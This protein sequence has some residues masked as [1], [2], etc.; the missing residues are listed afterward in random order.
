MINNKRI[1]ISASL[2]LF[3]VLTAACSGNTSSITYEFT[4]VRRG[5]LERT[6]SSSGTIRPVS[7]VRI[8]P[9]MSGKVERVFVDFNDTVNRG[10]IL[11]QLNTDMLRLRRQQ[12]NAAV[13]KARANYELQLLNYN[14]LLLLAERNLISEYELRISRTNLDNLAA[15]LEVAETNLSVIETEI[16][17]YAYIT[18]P[19]NGIVLDRMVNEG[20]S[21]SDSSGSS[22]LTLAENLSEMQ[23]EASIGELDVSSIYRGQAVRFTL[24]SL[25]GRRFTGTVENIRLVPAVVNNIISYTVIIKAEN[26]DGSLLPGMTCV[27]EF[28]VA[29]SENT[30]LVSNSALRYQPT[31]LSAEEIDELLFYADLEHMT[32]AQR[33]TAI[34]ARNQATADRAASSSQ[35]QRT[36]IVALLTGGGNNARARAVQAQARAVG[37]QEGVRYL[38]YMND[39]GALNVM[40][41]R[42]GIVT[43][44]NTE[45]F[46]LEDIEGR[47]FISRE[48]LQ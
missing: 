12:Q 40:R 36:G 22:I 8:L 29:R 44:S 37:D 1:A 23:I 34:E 10:D 16:N 14:N 19:I 26:P 20:D 42:I 39:N 30:L 43:G 5:T 13:I 47:Q 3:L 4:S 17:Q 28:I 48:R 9:Q 2:A 31:G 46:S 45:I 11:V 15:D 33:T 27:V 7:T 38:W 35:N 24:E 18:S 41:V 25:P 6:V 32:E 21:V